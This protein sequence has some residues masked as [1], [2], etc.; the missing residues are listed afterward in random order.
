MINLIFYSSLVEYAIGQLVRHNCFCF[1]TI[2]RSL[3]SCPGTIQNAPFLHV[4]VNVCSW[5]LQGIFFQQRWSSHKMLYSLKKNLQKM[6]LID[7]L[8]IPNTYLRT[9]HSRLAYNRQI[10]LSHQ[11]IWCVD[12]F[13]ELYIQWRKYQWH[14]PNHVGFVQ[15]VV[16]Q[17]KCE[18]LFRKTYSIT[19]SRPWAFHLRWATFINCVSST[20]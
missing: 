8:H 14:G 19:L 5:I 18:A 15:W 2:L 7:V 3:L 17:F 12:G 13:D 11:A 16:K 10:I 9:S 20:P 4:H 1:K 6:L